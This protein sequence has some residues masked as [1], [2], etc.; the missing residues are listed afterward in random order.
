M[1]NENNEK[2]EEN[3]TEENGKIEENEIVILSKEQ[4]TEP[5]EDKR[6]LKDIELDKLTVS[7]SNPRK[8]DLKK[9]IDILIADLKRYGL[10]VPLEVRRNGEFYE[11]NQGQ[12]RM[13]AAR[14][15]GWKKIRCW[16]VP[17][18]SKKEDD[19]IRSFIEQIDRLDL[20]PKDRSRVVNDF[21]ER[22][23][24]DWIRLSEILNRPVRTLK[25]WADFE[26]VPEQIKDMVPKKISEGY[27]RKLVRFSEV[28]PDEMVKIAEKM[29]VI[30]ETNRKDAIINSIKKSPKITA[31]EIDKKIEEH[32]E[33]L[34]INI[35]FKARIAK[36]IKE[37][38]EKRFEDPPA[39]V[40][41]IIREYL[42]GKGLLT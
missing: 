5:P 3:V 21:A 2:K 40:L 12:R 27:A 29:S 18:D 1:V 6:E 15:L 7:A 41:S 14:A 35:I 19:I 31:S 22:Y 42:Q 13:M 10:M 33:E 26:K 36:I 38:G 32:D 37:E 17:E 16:V 8:T 24:Y 11:V 34:A 23:D 4:V 20:L 9:D 28:S 30:K 39:F 25:D